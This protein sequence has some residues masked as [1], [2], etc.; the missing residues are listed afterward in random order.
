MELHALDDAYLQ[1]LKT[2]DSGVE[3]HFTSYFRELLLLK[4]RAHC[5]EPHLVDDVCQETFTRVLAA[6]RQVDNDQA[7]IRRAE[8]LGAFV[9]SVSNHVLRE[10]RRRARRNDCLEVESGLEIH[11]TNIDLDGFLITKETQETVRQV[12]AQLPEKDRTLLR[13]VFLEGRDK[14]QVCRE[15]GVARDYLRVLM[16]RAKARFR[17]LYREQCGLELDWCGSAQGVPAVRR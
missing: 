13:A 1:L 6:V 2:G 5:L 4:L 12:L 15:F 17:C 7:G 14:D 9:N 3:R 11:D 8:C 10:E 16:H